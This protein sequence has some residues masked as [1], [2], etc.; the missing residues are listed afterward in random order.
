[1][2]AKE[3]TFP[4]ILKKINLLSFILCV[5]L[6]AGIYVS[7]WGGQKITCEFQFCSVLVSGNKSTARFD[8]AFMN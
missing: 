4:V 8:C 6:P 5:C 3:L 1:M 2:L 7:H